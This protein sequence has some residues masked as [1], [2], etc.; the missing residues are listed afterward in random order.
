MNDLLSWFVA[1]PVGQTTFWAWL[2]L[3]AALLLL[4]MMLGTQWML[5]AAASAGLVS[6]ISLT[7]LPIGPASQGAIFAALTLIGALFS[8][9]LM[10]PVTAHNINDPHQRWVGLHGQV[11][12]GFEGA[13]ADRTGRVLVQGV[14]W[15]AEYHGRAE[16]VFKPEDPVKIAA[17]K[18]GR[19]FI[20]PLT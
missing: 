18:D 10:K 5:W 3:G 4:E 12:S 6:V 7:G 20:E 14:E 17:M 2:I 11:L 19:I 8:K 15:P 9:R 1:T 13:G 16:T